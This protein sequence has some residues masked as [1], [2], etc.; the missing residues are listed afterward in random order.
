MQRWLFLSGDD[1]G[2]MTAARWVSLI[3]G[4]LL[5]PCKF[6]A[7]NPKAWD[8]LGL[9]IQEAAAAALIITPLVLEF[10]ERGGR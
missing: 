4:I 7:K 5:M 10:L 9:L 8:I 2:H 3:I 1:E 6:E